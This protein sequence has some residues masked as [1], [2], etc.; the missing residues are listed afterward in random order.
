MQREYEYWPEDRLH[1]KI[2]LLGKR[3]DFYVETASGHRFIAEV[4]SFTVM[5]GDALLQ[6]RTGGARVEWIDPDRYEGCF[7]RVRGAVKE[8]A[9][10]LRPYRTLAIPMIV[11]LITG[12]RLAFQPERMRLSRCL[13]R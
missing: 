11:I 10:Q 3:P 8:A 12:G 6:S 2:T 1:E 13:G 7:D 4:K 5:I 9:K